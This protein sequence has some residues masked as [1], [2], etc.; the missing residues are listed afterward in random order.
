MPRQARELGVGPVMA[1]TSERYRDFDTM[2]NVLSC[3]QKRIRRMLIGLRLIRP[4]MYEIYYP[5]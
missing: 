2:A 3:L 5:E 4:T 1:D